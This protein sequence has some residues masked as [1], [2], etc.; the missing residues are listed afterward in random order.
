MLENSTLSA[1][2]QLENPEETSV[3]PT[4][5]TDEAGNSEIDPEAAPSAAAADASEAMPIVENEIVGSEEEAHTSAE[6]A[7]NDVENEKPSSES[8]TNPQPIT[9]TLINEEEEGAQAAES[10]FS[11]QNEPQAETSDAAP[12]NEFSEPGEAPSVAQPTLETA[13]AQ[14]LADEILV[15]DEHEM[16][17]MESQDAAAQEEDYSNLD[18][19][20]LVKV[21]EQLNRDAEPNAAHRALQ[22][23]KPLFDALYSKDKAE[24]LE[25]FVSEGGDATTFE[26][27]HAG[28]EQ[29]LN[30][31][32][33]G[34]YEK[35]KLSQDFQQKEKT[36]NLEAKLTLLEQL[37]QLVGDH[38]H[39]P[40]YDKFK[41][42]REEWKKIGPVG[43]EYAQNLN[44]SYYSL[45]EQFYSL[46]EIYHNL[47]DFDRKKNLDQKLELI[48]KIEKLADEPLI[49]K[50]MKDLMGY[51]DE[52]RSL[53]PV[54]KDRLD[55]LKDRLKKAVDVLYDRRRAF[56]EERKTMI[57]EE[58][59]L[60]QQLLEQLTG[61]ENFVSASAKEWQAKTKEL[62]VLQEEWKKIPT[63]FREKTGDLNKQFWAGFKKFMSAKNDFFKELD[64]GKKVVMEQ[65][66]SIID[67]INSLKDGDD[68]DGIANRMKELQQAWKNS[69][70]LFGKDGQKLFEAFKAGLDHFFNRLR[71]R[72]T[73]EDK[74]QSENL[75][76]KESICAEIEEL[77][78][79]GKG[80][81]AL[82]DT[83]KEKFRGAGF[84]PMK[85]MQRINS[86]FSKAMI[87]MID[88]AESIAENEKERLKISLLSNR[89]TYSAEGV[90]TL[91]NQEGYIQ[92]RLQQL[93]KDVGTLEDNVAMFKMSKNAMALIEDVQKR[94]NLAHLEIKELE[95]QLKEIRQA[96]KA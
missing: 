44:A 12:V 60:K 85:A 72:R 94:I 49:S 31:A 46:S 51:Q 22:K 15:V 96:D 20:Q 65:R 83:L 59:T 6:A 43:P 57:A 8:E 95:S 10:T 69:A 34:I 62:L 37:R 63:R 2:N 79:N 18:K 56:N 53:G 13:E 81:K 58:T 52:Y 5:T 41:V 84:V 78:A 3:N 77:A 29:R 26:Y 54:P 76:I 30:Q 80:T 88:K 66:Q 16:E 73:D 70:P 87:D 47:R 17:A 24:A 93:R 11:S 74:V 90:K 42:I 71:E 23:I 25:K 50:A 35:R 36:K 67:E 89:A 82:L 27:K 68:F 14:H 4:Q 91:R 7:P 38:E 48:A 86:R 32:A 9:A 1:D 64:K 19:E 40:G 39:T 33:K 21:V 75:A 92:K 28:L 55:E 45:I 61:F